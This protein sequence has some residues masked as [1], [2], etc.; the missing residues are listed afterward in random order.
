M[1]PHQWIVFLSLLTRE[2]TDRFRGSRHT[3]VFSGVVLLLEDL[4]GVSRDEFMMRVSL[5][6]DLVKRVVVG[7]Q[8]KQS[9]EG[10]SDE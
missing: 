10:S 6:T 7:R 1:S 9:H 2:C 4:C 5:N 3:A 8:D